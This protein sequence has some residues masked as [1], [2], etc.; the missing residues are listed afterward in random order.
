MNPINQNSTNQNST[1]HL[2]DSAPRQSI[3]IATWNVNGL[4]SC[5]HKGFLDFLKTDLDFVG[6]QELRALESNLSPELLQPT[7]YQTAFFPAERKGYSGVAVYS[8]QPFT[9]IQKGMGIP[10]FDVE[11]RVIWVKLKDIHIINVYFP[12]GAGKDGDNSRVPYKI[13]FYDAL[14]QK[15]KPFM[16]QGEKMIVMGDWNTAYSEIDL[17]NPK[18]NVNTSGFL[19]EERVTMGK[20]FDEGWVDAFRHF[21]PNAPKHYTWWSFRTNARARNIGWRID[22]LFVSPALM[23]SVKNAWIATDVMGS[24]HCPVF[25]EI[26]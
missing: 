1:N 2:N 11:G 21:H 3:K 4:R 7:H 18:Q 22:T 24:D 23:P 10:E 12:N 26:L 6:I 5:E 25:I 14:R 16:D 19:I 15:L 20:W 13:A 9:L 8:K 17:A